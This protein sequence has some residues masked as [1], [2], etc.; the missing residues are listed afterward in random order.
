M[1]M[2]PD[3]NPNLP[4]V[5]GTGLITLS[6]QIESISESSDSLRPTGSVLILSSYQF[7][8]T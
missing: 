1:N 3:S 2:E 6:S 5:E 8:S 7:S 4:V